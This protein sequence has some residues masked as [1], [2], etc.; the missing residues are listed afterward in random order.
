MTTETLQ[1]V[2]N[3]RAGEK[4]RKD[5]DFL[6]NLYTI[7]NYK[8]NTIFNDIY[9]NIGTQDK[10]ETVKAIHIFSSSK[11]IY[12]EAFE[13]NLPKYIEKETTLFLQE[14]EELKERVETLEEDV[15]NTFQ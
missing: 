10:P 12:K 15:Q 13:K 8:Y 11:R 4:L 3:K 7:D 5:L 9:I 14:I 2:I 1:Q 6:A